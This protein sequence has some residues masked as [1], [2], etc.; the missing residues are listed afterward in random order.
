[1]R[2]HGT[3]RTSTKTVGDVMKADVVTVVPEMTVA[4]L[5]QTFLDEHVR[6]APVL[7]PTGKV[8]GLVSETDVLRLLLPAPAEVGPDTREAPAAGTAFRR[9]DP[10]QLRVGEIMRPVEVVFTPGEPLASVV[11]SFSRDALQRAVVIENEILLGIVTPADLMPSL[12][13][14]A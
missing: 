1:M 9:R 7:G 14:D 12:A 5:V 11:R 13:G 6:G 2:V 4:E 10:C 8:I 3:R